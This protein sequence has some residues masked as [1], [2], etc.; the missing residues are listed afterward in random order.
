MQSYFAEMHQFIHRVID[1][2]DIINRID[3][4]NTANTCR[5]FKNIVINVQLKCYNFWKF[6]MGNEEITKE[7]QIEHD[8]HK[9]AGLIFYHN[10]YKWECNDWRDLV[11]TMESMYNDLC[12]ILNLNGVTIPVYYNILGHNNY[13]NVS[14]DNFYKAEEEA[15]ELD[16]R[17]LINHKLMKVDGSISIAD[18]IDKIDKYDDKLYWLQRKQDHINKVIKNQ[19]NA[20][21]LSKLIDNKAARNDYK[22][23]KELIE[24]YDAYIDVKKVLSNKIYH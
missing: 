10:R 17:A 8:K 7:D 11:V 24:A 13:E 1:N 2:K 19:K 6:I 16:A 5:Q 23:N 14:D 18:L 12:H 3:I 4:E 20:Y 15:L 22:N 9:E 21:L